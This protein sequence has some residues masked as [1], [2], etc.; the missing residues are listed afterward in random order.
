MHTSKTENSIA[1]LRV[2]FF[3]FTNKKK[4]QHCERDGNGT[5]G[6][7]VFFLIPTF[8]K[9]THTHARN[10]VGNNFGVRPHTYGYLTAHT[11]T[12]YP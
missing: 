4:E 2:C 12:H 5:L 10:L 11:R 3:S 1:Y 6:T 8:V 7:K 9:N